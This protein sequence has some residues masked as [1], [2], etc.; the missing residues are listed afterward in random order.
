MCWGRGLKL[1][2][3]TRLVPNMQKLFQ[4]PVTLC[5][6][7]ENTIPCLLPMVCG[8]HFYGRYCLWP[9]LLIIVA[10]IV[11]PGADPWSLR[12]DINLEIKAFGV[13]FSLSSFD[14][15]SIFG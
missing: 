14:R 5:L 7:P 4:C 11:N 1:Y 10:V 6:V 15:I 13:F 9:L 3:L 8:R 12:F 2:S